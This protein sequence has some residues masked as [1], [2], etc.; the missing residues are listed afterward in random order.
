MGKTT[1]ARLLVLGLA[2]L[3]GVACE[4]GSV[5][6]PSP[7]GPATSMFTFELSAS[8][9][10]LYANETKRDTALIKVVVKEAGIPVK[11]AVV[12]FSCQSGPAVFADYTSRCVAVSN[13]NG[14]A[15]ATLLGPLMSEITAYE[16]SVIVSAEVETT[17]PRSYYKEISLKVLRADDAARL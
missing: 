14:V 4:R 9:N 13:E 6:E 7:F 5:N 8:P 1:V 15:T 3:I 2:V 11:D 10:I 12:Y 16:L 17:S